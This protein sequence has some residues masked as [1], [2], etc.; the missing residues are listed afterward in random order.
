MTNEAIWPPS[1]PSGTTASITMTLGEVEQPRV[2]PELD[3]CEVIEEDAD[4]TL[5]AG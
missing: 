4:S 3:D 2:L 1:S 5:V